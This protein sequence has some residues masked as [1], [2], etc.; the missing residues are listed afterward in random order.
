MANVDFNNFIKWYYGRDN[1]NECVQML[2]DDTGIDLSKY[3]D[4][5]VE[6][7][8]TEY[9]KGCFYAHVIN[10]EDIELDAIDNYF[11]TII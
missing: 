4:T 8:V 1:V 11:N 2:T 3:I 10:G 6:L 7:V 9:E 5:N